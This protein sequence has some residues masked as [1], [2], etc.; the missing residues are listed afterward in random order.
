MTAWSKTVAGDPRFQ[1]A[2]LGL[3]VLNAVVM[4]LETSAALSSA[5]APAFWWFHVLVQAAFVIEIGIRL[6]AHGARP[7]G[8]FRDGWNTFDVAVVA[9][10]LVPAVGPLAT[11]A[12]LARILRI[13]RLLSTVPELR[14]IVG[15]MLRSIPAMGHVLMLLGLLLYGYGII[16]VSLFGPHDPARWGSLG[17]ALMTLFEVM[18]LEG[19]VEM[20]EASLRATPWAW[21]FYVSFIVVTVFIVVNLFIAVVINNLDATKAAE[22][23]AAQPAGDLAGRL[24]RLKE[25]LAALEALARQG[26]L[27]S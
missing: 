26:R 5:Y 18:T 21:I 20:L 27:G 11:I 4:G 13:A 6:M 14:L 10:A 19:W 23:A 12:R 3:I 8:F 9:A 24:H 15:T 7:G 22:A 1:H 25:E 2:V 17:R 16:G